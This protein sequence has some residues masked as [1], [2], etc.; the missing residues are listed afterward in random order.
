MATAGSHTGSYS[1][2]FVPDTRGRRKVHSRMQDFIELACNRREVWQSALPGL[3]WW[4][5]RDRTACTGPSW[6]CLTPALTAP[7]LQAW[8]NF[9]LW[10]CDDKT[11][12]NYDNSN[13]ISSMNVLPINTIDLLLMT[14]T[15]ITIV[16]TITIVTITIFT[17]SG[18]W[19][20]FVQGQILSLHT[21]MLWH[22]QKFTHVAWHCTDPAA[23]LSWAFV[24]NFS[25]CNDD[26]S[27]LQQ[28]APLSF[29][30]KSLQRRIHACKAQKSRAK[31]VKTS[32]VIMPMI[33]TTIK[34]ALIYYH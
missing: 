25:L 29:L 2:L 4:L 17:L 14:I 22:L 10:R 9:R 27:I 33:P 15:T 5:Q 7:A 32:I 30:F 28:N 18:S 34:S 11:N 21:L 19:A 23:R 3:A 1:G 6:C 24:V 13:G 12:N 20:G 26:D 8:L 31:Y 16:I